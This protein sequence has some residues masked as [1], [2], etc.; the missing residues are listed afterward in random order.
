MHRS[1]CCPR[2]MS[3]ISKVGPSL[4][5]AN[6]GSAHEEA[7]RDDG[8]DWFKFLNALEMKFDRTP[9]GA[10][11]AKHTDEAGNTSTYESNENHIDQGSVGTA[12]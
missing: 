11:V 2:K 4:E 1:V 9:S 5:R 8:I 7:G 10:F 3:L 12:S 6:D